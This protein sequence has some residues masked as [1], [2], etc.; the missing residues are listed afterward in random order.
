MRTKY[1]H[2]S[3]IVTKN[4][5]REVCRNEIVLVKPEVIGQTSCKLNLF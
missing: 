5:N 3:E 2:E 4:T 1:I